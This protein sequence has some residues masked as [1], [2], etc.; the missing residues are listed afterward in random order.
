V[1][2]ALTLITVAQLHWLI[3]EPYWHHNLLTRVPD[4][5]VRTLRGLDLPW[6][7]LPIVTDRPDVLYDLGKNSLYGQAHP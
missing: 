1:V 5:Q 4:T 3:R 6:N 7:R 2:A